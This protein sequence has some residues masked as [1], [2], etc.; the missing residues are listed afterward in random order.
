MIENYNTL[1]E[2]FGH[3]SSWAL[4][5][6][7]K[8]SETAIIE[9]NK[10]KLHNKVI[11]VGLN[12]SADI[13]KDWEN[14]HSGNHDRKLKKLFNESSY[15]GAYMTDIIKE[16]PEADSSQTDYKDPKLREPNIKIFLDEMKLLG[17]DENALFILFGNE[18]KNIFFDELMFHYKN[19][20][21]CMHYSYRSITDNN[22]I[23]QTK[24]TLLGHYQKTKNICGTEKFKPLE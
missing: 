19:A 9:A 6:E 18:T 7:E 16:Y 20:V 10:D 3:T 8:L 4:W 13:N 21:H 24:E 5:S 14:F 1:K 17:V 23:I 15:H 22:Y 11:I 2:D 12:V